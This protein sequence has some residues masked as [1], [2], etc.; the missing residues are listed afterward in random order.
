MIWDKYLDKFD[1]PPS[2]F[3]H[4]PKDTDKF[5][6]IVEPRNNPLLISVIKNF[7]FLLQTRGWGLIVFHGSKNETMVRDAFVEWPNVIMYNMNVVN[8]NVG[9]Y[10]NLLMTG[11]FWRRLLDYGCKH[12]L[13]FQMDTILLNPELDAFLEYDYVGAPWANGFRGGV[14]GNGGL[15]L[16][17]VEKMLTIAETSP[18][19]HGQLC[20]EDVFFSYWCKEKGYH[21]PTRE[22]ASRFSVETIYHETPC[23]MHKPTIDPAL[24][25]TI[26][27][28]S[29]IHHLNP[30]M[31]F[32]NSYHNLS[33]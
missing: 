23:G 12:A 19:N 28:K 30:L 7:M 20:F 2:F 22:I 11:E 1:L 14:S 21:V 5:C 18:I 33:K 6:V 32:S 3:Q 16:R 8:L 27:E 15:S 9:S 29:Y 17:N 24:V 4:I 26:L 31:I 13:I 10:S 25:N